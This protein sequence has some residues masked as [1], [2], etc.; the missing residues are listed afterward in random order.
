MAVLLGEAVPV[1]DRLGADR[2]A[3]TVFMT[4]VVRG[5]DLADNTPRQIHLQRAL[6]LPL[7]SYL[8]TPLVRAADGEKLSKGHGARAVVPGAAALRGALAALELD[9][10]GAALGELLA[11]APG[12][13]ARAAGARRRR[14]HDGRRS[15]HQPTRK[16]RHANHRF[17]TAVRRHRRR[18]RRRSD[19]RPHASACTT[20]AGST[21][22][23]R[24]GAK[25]DF[26]Q[27]S[28]R[29]V[30]VRPRR[31]HGDPRLGRGRRRG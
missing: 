14:W 16:A 1:R 24:K 27:G 30:R 2:R 15:S 13:M 26:Q 8:H 20:P 29:P 3:H 25:F 4:H 23:A 21:R 19:R 9:A 18:Q 11:A 5:E 17:R 28:R 22:T 6:G 12:A 7:P 10:R 31:G